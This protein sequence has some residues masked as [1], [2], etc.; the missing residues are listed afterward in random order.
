MKKQQPPDPAIHAQLS[1]MRMVYYAMA[2]PIIAFSAIVY[3]LVETG[4]LGQPDYSLAPLLQTIAMIV[5]PGSLAAGYFVFKAGA[6]K[7]DSKLPLL[8][9]LRKYFVLVMIR[10]AIFEAGFLFCFIAVVLT[11]ELLFLTAAPII[12]F[13]FLLLRPTGE[14]IA[15]DLKLA[16]NEKAQVE[17]YQ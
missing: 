4:A 15:V 13:I 11:R 2:A 9:K 10:S 14:S 8:E 17:G 6:S 16:G 12:L 7:L 3:F 5:I 1:S